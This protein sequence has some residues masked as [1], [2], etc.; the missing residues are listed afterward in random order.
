M[1]SERIKKG[2]FLYT[3][4][5]KATAHQVTCNYMLSPYPALNRL[6]FHAPASSSSTFLMV[7][8]HSRIKQ[9]ADSLEPGGKHDQDT[10]DLFFISTSLTRYSPQALLC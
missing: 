3:N 9:K 5:F 7:S 4:W 2:D 10:G 8:D 6:T 1:F